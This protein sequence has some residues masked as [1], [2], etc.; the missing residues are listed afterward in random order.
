MGK[1]I[2][3]CGADPRKFCQPSYKMRASL[4]SQLSL[5]CY[6]I[7]YH[8]VTGIRLWNPSTLAL[9]NSLKAKG[10]NR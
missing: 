10:H 7:R 8:Y 9:V 6:L 2:W 1:H 3:S 5:H 4:L